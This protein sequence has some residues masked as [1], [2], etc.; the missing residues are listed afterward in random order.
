MGLNDIKY[1]VPVCHSCCKIIIQQANWFGPDRILKP[2]TVQSELH[3]IHWYTH[4]SAFSI[5]SNHQC[6]LSMW[7]YWCN[8]DWQFWCRK[9]HC[10]GEQHWH[11]ATQLQLQRWLFRVW[12]LT[13]FCHW[14][15]WLAKVLF[16]LWV[17][18]AQYN[19][20]QSFFANKSLKKYLG[21]TD[22]TSL[23]SNVCRLRILLFRDCI[24]QIYLFTIPAH[25]RW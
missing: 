20:A 22:W 7:Q 13:L 25:H 23:W 2:Y 18:T 21:L 15:K 6:Q 11:P 9:C 10:W 24:K 3:K 16:A 12:F 17:H 4:Y 8:S 14:V 1:D 5:S 19:K